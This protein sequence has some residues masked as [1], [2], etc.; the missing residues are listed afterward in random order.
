MW[1]TVIRKSL[2]RCREENTC[3]PDIPTMISRRQTEAATVLTRAAQHMLLGRIQKPIRK[4]S[5]P[6][7]LAATERPVL[8]WVN[9]MRR[10]LSA[11]MQALRPARAVPPAIPM[12]RASDALRPRAAHSPVPTAKAEGRQP[13]RA[14]MQVREGRQ[15]LLR[16][17]ILRRAGIPRPAADITEILRPGRSVRLRPAALLLSREGLCRATMRAI[18]PVIQAAGR[19]AFR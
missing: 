18:I 15:A 7:L 6:F 1:Y 10:V 11:A 5:A 17:E 16:R 19:A 14:A 12:S 2:T 9:M 13:L 8:L 4:G 3:R